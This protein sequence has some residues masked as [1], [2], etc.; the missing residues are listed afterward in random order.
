MLS[1]NQATGRRWSKIDT[2]FED[3]YNFIQSEVNDVLATFEREVRMEAGVRKYRSNNEDAY[4]SKEIPSYE[5]TMTIF[6]KIRNCIFIHTILMA[7]PQT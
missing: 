1:R 7:K 2:T 4:E 3:D 5:V 6:S